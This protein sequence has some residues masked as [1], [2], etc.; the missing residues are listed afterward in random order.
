MQWKFQN[1][2]PLY[3]QMLCGFILMKICSLFAAVR[4]APFNPSIF[5]QWQKVAVL[6]LVIK[7]TSKR[8]CQWV[9]ESDFHL[10]ISPQTHFLLIGAKKGCNHFAWLESNDSFILSTLNLHWWLKEGSNY[11]AALVPCKGKMI[12]F[13]STRVTYFNHWQEYLNLSIILLLFD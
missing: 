3:S 1:M 13:I 9:K 6:F 8:R 10:L 2:F 7:L 11:H 12:K 5:Q 4:C